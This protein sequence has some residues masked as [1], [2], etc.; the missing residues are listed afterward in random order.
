MGENLK[1]KIITGLIILNVLLLSGMF[2]AGSKSRQV[3]IARDKE[4]NIRFDAQA[5]LYNTQKENSLLEDK[6]RKAE[7]AAKSVNTGLAAAQKALA[8]EQQINQ[9]LRAELEKISG[10]K[11]SLEAELKNMN[12]GKSGRGSKK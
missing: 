9:D 7:D 11:D 2:I 4:M 3:K 12:S 8:Q 6:L 1:N 10:L 5:D